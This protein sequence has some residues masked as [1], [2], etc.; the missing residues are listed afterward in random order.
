MKQ[1]IF[2]K[3]KQAEAFYNSLTE[4]EKSAMDKLRKEALKP[5]FEGQAKK[6]NSLQSAYTKFIQTKK[7]N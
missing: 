1:E 7:M 3:K 4:Q 2:I 5:Y 6:Q